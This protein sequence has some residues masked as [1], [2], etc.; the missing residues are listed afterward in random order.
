[1]ILAVCLA[2]LALVFFV[3]RK[4]VGPA[5]LAVI[6]GVAVYQMFGVALAGQI[7]TWITGWDLWWIEKILYFLLVLVFPLLLYLRSPRGGRGGILRVVEAGVFA[8][9]LTALLARP[10]SEIVGFDSLAVD[11]SNWIA[12]VEGYVVMAGIAFAYL[13]ILFYKREY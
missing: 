10:L 13:D 9:L 1:M 7:N 4:N 8:V 12:G 11:I 5:L 3:V 6:A 2:L